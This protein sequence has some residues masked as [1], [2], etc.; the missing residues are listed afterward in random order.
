MYYEAFMDKLFKELAKTL[1]L[2]QIN[3]EME[4]SEEY[5]SERFQELM[6]ET[7]NLLKPKLL[8]K[9][10]KRSKRNNKTWITSSH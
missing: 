5:I 1:A 4:C 7:Y 3:N 2:E 8:N 6:D 9:A 10:I